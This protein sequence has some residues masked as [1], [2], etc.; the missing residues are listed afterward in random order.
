MYLKQNFEEYKE[1]T[2]IKKI[3]VLI[4]GIIDLFTTPVL[5]AWIIYISLIF[6]IFGTALL[7]LT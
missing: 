4:V 2:P 6:I 5:S 1:L 7:V 3:L